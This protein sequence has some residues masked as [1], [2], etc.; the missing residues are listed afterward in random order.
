[1]SEIQ[2]PRQPLSITQAFNFLKATK[3]KAVDTIKRAVS[4]AQIS[5]APPGDRIKFLNYGISLL[6][7]VNE[8]EA[9]HFFK[10]T[11]K[12]RAMYS[13]TEV[14]NILK[15][16]LTLRIH[17]Y[18]IRQIAYILK[19]TPEIMR[20]VEI[21]AI[22]ACNRSIDKAKSEKLPLIGGAN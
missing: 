8:E 5:V 20:K 1:M 17:K 15:Q 19:T 18:S 2:A 12:S 22:S 14:A 21:I 3:D 9:Y 4:K 7:K 11:G 13:D 16:V 10:V 6:H